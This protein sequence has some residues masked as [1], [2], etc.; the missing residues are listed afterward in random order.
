MFAFD[1]IHTLR[2]EHSDR[3]PNRWVA[4]ALQV[5]L[6][7]L[8]L[9]LVLNEI[10]IFHLSKT[11]MRVCA[12][13]GTVCAVIPMVLAG[14][15]KLSID[16]RSKYVILFCVWFMCFVMSLCL[17]IFAAPLCVLPMFVA[18]QY[19]SRRLSCFAIAGSCV[20]AAVAPPLGC[21]MGLWDSEFLRFLISSAWGR[22]MII[23]PTMENN[24][25]VMTTGA[26]GVTMFLSFPWLLL[27]LLLGKLLLSV[28][29]KGEESIDTQVKVMQ[30][31]QLDALTGLYNQNIY[32]RYLKTPVQGDETVGVMFFDVDGLKRINDDGGHE[33]GDLLLRRCAESLHTLLDDDCH[34]F[35]IGGDEFLLVVD[36]D[37]PAVLDA[38]LEQWRKAIELINIENR[39]RHKGLVCHMSVGKSFGKKYDLPELIVLAD[40]R[41]YTEKEAY[42]KERGWEVR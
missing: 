31:S 20:C 21:A 39:T 38:K 17:F 15:D 33:Q 41:M 14:S 42:H 37:D 16:P 13:L 26:L 18:A 34:G 27:M 3:R 28:T 9:C 30:M 25:G 2:A 19:N 23:M 40:G 35:R 1:N 7:G 12:A 36:T 11:V 32:N 10:N 4:A 22:E 24:P 6:I 29:R 5:G 8:I